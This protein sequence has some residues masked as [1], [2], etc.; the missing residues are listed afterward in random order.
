MDSFYSI[1]AQYKIN[2]YYYYFFFIPPLC[3]ILN[4]VTFIQVVCNVLLVYA[5]RIVNAI[6]ILH[7]IFACF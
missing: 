4:Q 1:S 2:D 6:P 3:T 7:G 5:G